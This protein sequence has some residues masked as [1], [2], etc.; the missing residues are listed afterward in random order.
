MVINYKF[1][2]LKHSRIRDIIKRYVEYQIKEDNRPKCTL[3]DGNGN[4]LGE[5]VSWEIDY[6]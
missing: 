6:E 3:S 4:I 1:K 2:R 5:V